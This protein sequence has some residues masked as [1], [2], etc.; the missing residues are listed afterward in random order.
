MKVLIVD[1]ETI[2]MVSMVLSQSQILEQEVFL[3]EVAEKLSESEFGNEKAVQSMRHLK[4]VSFLRP[5]AINFLFLTKELKFPRYSGYHMFFTNVV[6]HTRLEQLAGCDEMELVQEVQEIFLD[7]FPIN[8]DLFSLNIPA[9]ASLTM[10]SSLW[11]S[12]EESILSRIVDGIFSSAVSLGM[13]PFVRYPQAS[14]LCLRIGQL[15]QAKIDEEYTLFQKVAGSEGGHVVPSIVLLFD[16]RADAITPLLNQWT[17]QAMCHELVGLEN[18]RLK[19]NSSSS[20][21]C[22]EI[23]LSS[24]QDHFYSENLIS[25]FGDLALNI[26]RLVKQYQEHARAEGNNPSSIKSIEEMQ[27]FIEKYPEFKKTSGNVSKHVSV[28]HELSR[29]V[30]ASHLIQLSQLEQEIACDES[31]IAQEAVKKISSAVSSQ[32]SPQLE[33]LRLVLLFSLRYP[34]ETSS[35]KQLRTQ[36]E[37]QSIQQTADLIDCLREYVSSLGFREEFTPGGQSAKVFSMIRKAVGFS[38]IENVYTQHK[39]GL[40]YLLDSVLRG[41]VK[42]ASFPVVDSRRRPLVLKEKPKQVIAFVVGGATYEEA[43]DVRVLNSQYGGGV[44]LGGTTVHNSKSFL[45]DVAQRKRLVK[46]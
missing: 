28:V 30:T 33:K 36:L 16:R 46:K 34:F 10:E 45:A 25:N 2:G 12:Y 32:D 39:S 35:V 29:L 4:A 41:K 5:T 9:T 44:V 20:S 1:S 13:Y 24:G 42:D 15:L 21:S 8:S 7:V 40:Y 37:T 19:L 18:N 31:L 3:V 23:V 6:P 17:Y 38:G 26:E 43:R 14:A 27:R 22:S 11:T